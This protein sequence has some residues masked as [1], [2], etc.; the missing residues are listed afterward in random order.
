MNAR[1]FS[2]AVQ[3]FR[4]GAITSNFLTPKAEP[5]IRATANISIMVRISMKEDM[6]IEIRN[7]GIP[8]GN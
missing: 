8:N 4:I 6:G 3:S 2:S 5:P 7:D 1:V